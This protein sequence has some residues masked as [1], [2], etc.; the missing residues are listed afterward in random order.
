MPARDKQLRLPSIPRTPRPPRPLRGRKAST[1]APAAP[2]VPRGVYADSYQAW[3]CVTLCVD[4]GEHCGVAV[5]RV[6][7]YVDSGHGDG[8]DLDFIGRWISRTALYARKLELPLVLV[9]EKPPKGGMP[10]EGRNAFGGA[11]VLACRKLWQRAWKQCPVVRTRLSC[12]VYPVTWR[13]RILGITSGEQLERA[14]FR[15]AAQLAQRPLTS[16]DEAAACVIGEWS[17]FAGAVG[18]VL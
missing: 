16:R 12:D 14:E 18:A 7:K 13:A 8:F 9:R 5:F 4:P 11:S 2:R 15:R 17:C 3:Q 10:Y 1:T 6:G